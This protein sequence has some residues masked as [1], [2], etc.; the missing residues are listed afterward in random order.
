MVNHYP[1]MFAPIYK[2]MVW[3]G[4][5]LSTVCNRQLPYKK[6]GESWDI[7]CRTS[8]MG[9]IENGSAA[10]MTF[11]E[12]IAKD[13]EGTL[14]TRLAKHERFPLLV[15][16]IDANDALS[17]QVHPDDI[18]ATKTDHDN[19]STSQLLNQ[20]HDKIA[21]NGL[22]PSPHDTGKNEMWY[23][24]V[25][26]TDGNLI[27]GLKSGITPF[28]LRK[29]YE[30]NIV[31]ECLNLLPV[32][33]G[34][35]VNIPAGLIHALTPGVMVAEVQQNSDITYRLYDYN[36]TGLDGKPRQL[37]VEDAIAVTDFESRIPKNSV[38]GLTIK[39]SDC[40]MVYAIANPYFAVIKY[41]LSGEFYEK[42]D[43]A[44]FC[45]FT[46]VDGEAAIEVEEGKS[47]EPDIDK[48]VSLT[49]GRSV[50]IPAGLGGYTIRPKS[51]QTCVLIK[52]F[53]P[54]IEKDFIAPLRE[55]GY[56]DKDIAKN[57][58]Y[59]SIPD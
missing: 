28:T 23:I 37:H 54:D 48:P 12:Y 58:S 32:K 4:D 1:L 20:N 9:I 53:V 2:E 35:I 13:R 5:R 51:G 49:L 19:I 50:F 25:P 3:G 40:S 30:N 41:E 22:E 15:K 21:A 46:C 42:S 38:P 27:I 11:D 14:G 36:R 56:T 45:V 59:Y 18:Y 44:A 55:N 34:D 16:L 6:T 33:A 7:T 52:C 39:K 29:A 47:T 43:P 24:L 10:G 57:T 26:P 17:V 31:E 8:E